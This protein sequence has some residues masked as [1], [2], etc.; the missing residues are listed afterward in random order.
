MF[1]I[2]YFYRLIN[3]ENEY[4]VDNI[5]FGCIRYNLDLVKKICIKIN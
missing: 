4:N 1:L 3:F 5:I 2:L